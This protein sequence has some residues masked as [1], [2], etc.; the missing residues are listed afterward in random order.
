MGIFLD[1]SGA[2]DNLALAS[3]IAGLKTKGVAENICKWYKFY[4][5]NRKATASVAGCERSIVLKKGMPQGGVLSPVVWN[6]NFDGVL[7]LFDDSPVLATLFADDLSLLISG[8]D[9][10]T[11]MGIAQDAVDR[12]V[13]WGKKSGLAFSNIKTVV[14]LF[15]HKRANTERARKLVMGGEQIPFSHSAKYL[16]ILFDSRLNFRE[17]VEQKCKKAI[18]LL[19]ACRNALGRNWGLSVQ[20]LKWMYDA[21]IRPMVCY[22]SIV[23]ANRISPTNRFLMRVQRLALLMM[24]SFLK[25]TP[26][27]G[28]EIIFSI[29][30][31]HLH[32]RRKRR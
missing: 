30:P 32:V 8:T 1:I 7:Q 3:A 19:M 21:I 11:M 9:L 31:L 25:S 27:A 12:T 4:L 20:K 18:R 24:G 10:P 28:L 5:H 16:G 13:D 15:S 22:G 23:W 2:F 29:P 14:V 17:Q 26:T 6:M